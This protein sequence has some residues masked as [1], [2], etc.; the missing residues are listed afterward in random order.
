MSPQLRTKMVDPRRMAGLLDSGFAALA[1]FLMGIVSVRIL[2]SDLLALYA[3]F[4]YGWIIAQLI[5][6]QVVYF[7][8][9]LTVNLGTE[10]VA[11]RVLRD[12]WRGKWFLVLSCAITLLSGLPLASVASSAEYLGMAGTAAA[13]T[14]TS[15]FNAHIRASLH[16]VE[17]HTQASIVSAVTFG[18]AAVGTVIGVHA[19]LADGALIAVIPFGITV[20]ANVVGVIVGVRKLRAFRAGDYTL[21][22]LRVRLSYLGPELVSQTGGYV[23]NLLVAASLGT[24][25]LSQLQAAQVLVGPITVVAGAVA[26]VYS[27]SAIRALAA[28]QARDL[29]R[30]SGFQF[31]TC[32]VFGALYSVALLLFGPLIVRFLGSNASPHL[33]AARAISQTLGSGVDMFGPISFAASRQRVW[34]LA[35]LVSTAVSLLGL[36]ALVTMSSIGTYA[37]PVAQSAGT[38]ARAIVGLHGF[39]LGP[40]TPGVSAE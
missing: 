32:A 10:V 21:A 30:I 39:S 33:S 27:P 26:S 17:A 24:V 6:A 29:R 11:P 3:L 14:L 36:S 18:T 20:L 34:I 13:L 16:L 7:P 8:S 28:R 23:T 35:S 15:A 37:V 9:R 31:I 2:D 25:A 38:V 22:P 12:A 5:P 1:N 19:A 40:K 4:Y